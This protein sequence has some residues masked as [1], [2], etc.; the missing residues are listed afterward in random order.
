MR[1][2][3]AD[4]KSDRKSCV[5]PT[6]D[7]YIG[8]VY[9]LHFSIINCTLFYLISDQEVYLLRCMLL[10]TNMMMRKTI[11][12][13]HST[14]WILIKYFLDKMSPISQFKVKCPQLFPISALQMILH[15]SEVNHFHIR[16]PPNSRLVHQGKK[17]DKSTNK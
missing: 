3:I 8:R 2:G 17:M 5:I 14:I 11:F 7:R 6:A 1:S 12:M 16:A 15:L 4:H 13:R 9:T 10:Y